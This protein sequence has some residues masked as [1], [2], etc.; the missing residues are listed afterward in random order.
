MANSGSFNTGNYKGRYLVFAW[1]EKSQSIENNT[2][3][4]SWT[5]KGAGQAEWSYYLCQNIKVFI[6]DKVVFQHT[7]DKDGQIKLGI[8]TLVASGEYT[9]THND[10]GTRTFTADAE[11]GVYTWAVNCAGGGT[12][13]LDTIARASQP[14]L[15]TWPETT[16]DVGDFG[17]TFSIHMNRKSSAFTHTVRYAYGNRTGTIATGVTTGTTWA[18]PL[19]FMNDIPN[20]TSASGRIY[21]DTYNGDTKV[22]TKYTGFTVKVPASAKPSCTLTLKDTSGVDAIYGSPVQGLSTIQI[23]VNETLAYSSPIASKEITANGAKYTTEPVTTGVLQA[24]GDSPVAATI[25][26]KR[27]RSGSASYTMKVQAY[28]PPTVTAL[29]V[30]RC[31]AD[32]SEN[33]QGEY[34]GVTFSAAV[35]ALGNKNTAAYKLR[36]K[37]TADDTYTEVTLSALANQYQVADHLYIFAADESSSYDVEI[38]AT[39]RHNST[40]RATSASTAFSLMDWHPSGTGIAFGRVSQKERTMEI[41]LDVEFLGKVKG[42]IFDAIWPVGSIYLA[43]NHTDPATLF[44][45]TWVRMQD[46]FLWAS[47]ATDIIG[48]TGGAKEVTLTT[49]QLPAHS[50]GS[51]Y[52]QHAPGTKSQAWYTTAGTSL[53]YGAVETGG[54][55]AHNN[56]PP[57]IQVS[58]WRRTA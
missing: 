8:G 38:V 9:F 19:S 24:S 10:D 18:V 34:I 4:I 3:T 45:G 21:V 30:H 25:T 16:N 32:G 57:Y 12:F 48:Q 50:H 13:T 15:V 46:G 31:N 51:V 43:Y 47:R 44:G 33:D 52:S 27:G 26:D 28:A 2:T 41:S 7:K 39:D 42:T 5:L 23:T 40:T 35:T 54:G 1:T 17:E 20:A 36:Y 6:D 14:S 49:D 55:K 58:I 53:A 29:A 37:N 22:G 11:A 56:M